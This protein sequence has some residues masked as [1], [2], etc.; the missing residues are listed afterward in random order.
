MVLLGFITTSQKFIKIYQTWCHCCWK[1]AFLKQICIVKADNSVMLVE[2]WGTIVNGF[3]YEHRSVNT[4]RYTKNIEQNI[5]IIYLLC[6]LTTWM[7]R[8][9]MISLIV[10]IQTWIGRHFRLKLGDILSETFLPK[11]VFVPTFWVIWMGM[12]TIKW[13]YQSSTW[14]VSSDLRV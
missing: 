12:P 1:A 4:C 2:Y 9:Y 8:I 6:I 3:L 11:T 10:L 5:H 14:A 7:F 13:P